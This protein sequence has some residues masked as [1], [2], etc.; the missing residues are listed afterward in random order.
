MHVM[1]DER[2]ATVMDALRSSRQRSSA[3]VDRKMRIL[4]VDC[5]AST[6]VSAGIVS[7]PLRK[8]SYDRTC[9]KNDMGARMRRL[10]SICSFVWKA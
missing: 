2:A 6:P 5:F 3:N 7:S 10:C 1:A 4:D 9:D 8:L